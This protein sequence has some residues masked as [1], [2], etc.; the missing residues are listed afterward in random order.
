MEKLGL[1]IALAAALHGVVL[2]GFNQKSPKP[3]PLPKDDTVITQID[4]RPPPE[5][6][7]LIV[8]AGDASEASAPDREVLR[9][10][11]TPEPAAQ[12]SDSLFVIEKQQVRVDVAI[13]S[14][15]RNIVPPAGPVG[16]G[17]DGPFRPGNIIPSTMLDRVPAARL[18]GQPIY[19]FDAKRN[20]LS[21]QVMVDFT[22]NERGDVV[23]ARAVSSSDRVF[24]ES[25]T[26]AVMKWKFEPGRRNG[27]VVP[28]RMVIPIQFSLNE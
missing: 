12:L 6:P 20:G 4:L 16:P 22:V 25:A 3:P 13:N 17:G 27:G 21:G 8:P 2:F 9:P 28:F 24:E 7:E 15:M 14:D 19:P 1:P 10:P 18:Q 5:E 11:S 26:R 23:E